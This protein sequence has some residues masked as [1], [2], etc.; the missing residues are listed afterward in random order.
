MCDVCVMAA[1][2]SKLQANNLSFSG[3]GNIPKSEILAASLLS[4]PICTLA[5]DISFSSIVD[6]THTLTPDFPTFYGDPAFT[7]TDDFTFARDNMNGKTVSYYEHVGTHFDAPLHFS[8]NGQS[9]DELPLDKLV[10]PLAVIDVRVQAEHDPDYRILP[11]DIL[12]YEKMHGLIPE[13]ACV[14]ALSGW[15]RYVYTERFRGE[16]SYGVHHFPGFH[17]ST[18][19]FLIS[20]RQVYGIGIDTM[21]LDYGPTKDF[22]IH[23][24]WLGSGRYGI[25]S[26]TNLEHVPPAGATLIGGAPK[27]Q[28]G[29]GGPGRVIAVY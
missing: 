15:S 25:E 7:E 23:R 14:S 10:C 17:E 26:L 13:R 3:A 12:R 18:A 1:V 20:E 5:Q 21:S 29:T 16:D 22:S 11:E 19:R 4:A 24:T 6:L 9:I 27:F 2:K 8:P 28:G